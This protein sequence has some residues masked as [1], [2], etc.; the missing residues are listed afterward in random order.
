MNGERGGRLP[1]L[2]IGLTGGV[3]GIFCCVG[4]TLLALLGIVSAGTAYAWSYDLYDGYAWW[5]RLAGLGVMALLVWRA[6]RKRDACSVG[7][8]RA[9]RRKI[10]VA[11]AVAVGTYAILYAVTDALGRLAVG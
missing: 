5:F 3:V 6:L 1:A 8:V 11:L 9:A 10:V 2:R 4:P 7:G